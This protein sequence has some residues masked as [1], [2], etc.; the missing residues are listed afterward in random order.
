MIDMFVWMDVEG[1]VEYDYAVI[2]M[3]L[4]IVAGFGTLAAALLCRKGCGDEH[5]LG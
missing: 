3:A 4:D 1:R 5:R 2:V